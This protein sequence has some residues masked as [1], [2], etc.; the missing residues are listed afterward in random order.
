MLKNEPHTAHVAPSP[1]P[2]AAEIINLAK[3]LAAPYYQTLDPWH[4]ETHGERVVIAALEINKVEQADPLLVEVGAWL[5]QFHAPN[6][7][8]LE[9][10]LAQLPVSQQIRDELFEIV[11]LCRPDKISNPENGISERLLRAAQVVFDG[12]ALDLIGPSGI[13]REFACNLIHRNKPHQQ[14]LH[15]TKDVHALFAN[16]LQTDTAKSIA[17]GGIEIAQNIW[18]QFEAHEAML[19]AAGAKS[20]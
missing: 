3:S 12:D 1:E 4:N 18:R 20:Y 15:D 2:R 14:A 5:H 16:S 7:Q 10:V 19:I 17:Q 9:P 8:L 11:R 6:L 13:F